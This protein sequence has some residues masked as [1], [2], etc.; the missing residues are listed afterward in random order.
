V[1]GGAIAVGVLAGIIAG[2]LGVGGGS[3]FVPALVLFL[4]LSHLEAEAT[5]L[6]AI[7]PVA[8]VGVWRQHRYGNVRVG[9]AAALGALGLA[10]AAAGV[11]VAN[12][13]PERALEV[14]FA[15]FLLYVA[16]QLA[17]R[18]LVP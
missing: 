15:V 6:L 3:L 2:M 5:S 1:I 7:V 18:A 13:V 12:S 9:D 16:G 11:I 8:V 17:R 4:G 14:A 10:G